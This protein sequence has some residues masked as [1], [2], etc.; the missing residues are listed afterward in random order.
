MPDLQR[1]APEATSWDLSLESVVTDRDKLLSTRFWAH[2]GTPLLRALL[3]AKEE[4]A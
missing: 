2:Y 4:K 1:D 3:N